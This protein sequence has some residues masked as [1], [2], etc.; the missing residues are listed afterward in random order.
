VATLRVQRLNE[1]LQRSLLTRPPTTGWLDIAV[2]YLP[3]QQ[4]AHVGGDWYDA[5]AV[6]GGATVVCVGDVACHD[7]DA[8]ATMA[9]LRNLLRGLAVDSSDGPATLLSRL[10]AAVAQ[11]GLPALAT[12]VVAVVQP[13]LSRGAG[14]R[15][16][17]SSAGHLPPLVRLVGG[18]VRVLPSS[19]DLLL[20]LDA[21]AP[22]AEHVLDL[23]GD[24]TL[25]LCTDGLVERRGESLD[26]GLNRL[27]RAL[28][29]TG[30]AA[31]EEVC[32]RLLGALL[33]RAPDDDVAMLVLRARPVA[34]PATG[35]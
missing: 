15:V 9:Q 7:G 4:E 29:A 22:R 13:G 10:D 31:P 6:P 26:D 11:L 8:A 21:G 25:V 19:D 2:R 5:F 28:D 12:A 33:E 32:D 16:R 35:G 23:P 34:E 17:W 14:C 3:A 20:G 24:S 27:V 18:G 30:S 1:S